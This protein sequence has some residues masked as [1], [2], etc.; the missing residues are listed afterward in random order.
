M[1]NLFVTFVVS[2]L[3]HGAAWTFII[4]GA[5]HG[6]LLIVEK[7]VNFQKLVPIKFLRIVLVF[8]LVNFAWIFFRANSM[9]DALLVISGIFKFNWHFNLAD[10]CAY[11][12]PMN[13]LISFMGLGLFLFFQNRTYIREIRYNVLTLSIL[14]LLIITLGVYDEQQFIYF[15]F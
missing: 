6:I 5:I 3:W 10:F 2:G 12:G 9:H 11:K 1:R 7:E 13:L 4:W 15:Q 14:I 8:S